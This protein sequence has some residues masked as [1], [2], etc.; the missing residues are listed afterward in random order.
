MSPA[1]DAQQGYGANKG[2]E[3]RKMR[4]E[5]STQGSE[6]GMNGKVE[7]DEVELERANEIAAEVGRKRGNGR[8]TQA[9]E[10]VPMTLLKM[11]G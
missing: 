2:D 6:G 3:Q 10:Q 11:K 9:Q 1:T 5:N 4:E 7:D 8:K